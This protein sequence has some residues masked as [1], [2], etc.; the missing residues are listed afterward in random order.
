M[1]RGTCKLCREEDELCESH[2][3]PNFILKDAFPAETK[4][5]AVVVTNEGPQQ[6]PAQQGP[7]EPLLCRICEGR[8]QKWERYVANTKIQIARTRHGIL[9]RGLEYAP[10]RLYFLS[11]LWRLSVCK[12][13][14]GRAV[15]LGP[16]GD[17]LRAR[18]LNESPGE[19]EEY[20][21]VLFP[22]LHEDESVTGIVGAAQGRQW[23]SY[24]CYSVFLDRFY[25]F[26]FVTSHG[27]PAEVGPYLLK[28]DGS[29]LL[30]PLDSKVWWKGH[31]DQRIKGPR[32]Q[33]NWVKR[34]DA[35]RP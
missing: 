16:H 6:Q 17:V 35:R 20:P 33:P 3:F 13:V 15:K 1:E 19:P 30:P 25:A 18:L 32:D 34:M 29:I 5:R 4:H 11:I 9:A 14:A 12:D 21:F 28:K 2:I 10:M 7:R 26:F 23:G 22:L 24:R 27:F 31:L 8:F